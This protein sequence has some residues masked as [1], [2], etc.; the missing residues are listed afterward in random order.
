M[1]LQPGD[2]PLRHVSTPAKLT[3]VLRTFCRVDIPDVL[4]KV[5][6]AE[7]IA[8][9][10]FQKLHMCQHLSL[11]LFVHNSTLGEA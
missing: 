9:L 3:E 6:S 7:T 1:I 5:I 11:K 10:N 8:T 2:L 4:L